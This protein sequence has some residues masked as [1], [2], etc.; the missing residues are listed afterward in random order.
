MFRNTDGSRGSRWF[1]FRSGRRRTRPCS[2]F[3][4]CPTERAV[5]LDKAA[6]TVLATQPPPH[7]LMVDC[8]SLSFCDSS[9]I[10]GF[11]RLHQ[12][13]AAQQGQVRSAAPR[14]SRPRSSHSP[15]WT[16]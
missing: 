1:R 9:G 13:L 10:G 7:V 4:G 6:P 2:S 5:Q 3:E 8:A 14:R 15:G 11:V 16:A 12:R